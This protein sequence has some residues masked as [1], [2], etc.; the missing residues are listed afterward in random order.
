M[1]IKLSKEPRRVFG[2]LAER[3]RDPRDSMV[4]DPLE[5]E[6]RRLIEAGADQAQRERHAAEVEFARGLRRGG[7]LE[8][9]HTPF[10]AV[11]ARGVAG[12][13]ALDSSA[14]AYR[15]V[16][17]E[18]RARGGPEVNPLPASEK[19][20]RQDAEARN[21]GIVR[22]Q[23]ALEAGDRHVGGVRRERGSQEPGKG[24]RDPKTFAREVLDKILGLNR[25]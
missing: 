5:R 19:Y 18:D 10:S 4:G 21:R 7:M 17:L 13:R 16:K 20:K 6:R 23:A 12:Q 25:K 15:G 2:A 11:V 1:T 8:D 9:E 14:S 22:A 3:A 24:P